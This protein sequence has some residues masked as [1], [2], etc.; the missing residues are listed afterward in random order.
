VIGTRIVRVY[1]IGDYARIQH[2][3]SALDSVWKCVGDAW[4]SLAVAFN[5]GVHGIYRIS[6][7][8]EQRIYRIIFVGKKNVLIY[9]FSS[10]PVRVRLTLQNMDSFNNNRSF[11]QGHKLTYYHG[12]TYLLNT[13]V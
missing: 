7:R 1:V 12:M 11:K 2:D 4:D 10:N 6:T 3:W 5:S 9:S 8:N 13:A